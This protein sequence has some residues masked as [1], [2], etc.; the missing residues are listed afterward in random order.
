MSA[1]FARTDGV[2]TTKRRRVDESVASC[3]QCREHFV[4]GE[5]WTKFLYRCTIDERRAT[6][7]ALAVI[8][9]RCVQFEFI[10]ARLIRR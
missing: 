10:N 8:I 7:V 6:D 4:G 2:C 3:V 1:K 5:M 9:A